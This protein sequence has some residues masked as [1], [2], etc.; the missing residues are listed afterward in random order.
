MEELLIS[1]TANGTR[2]DC[3]A[4]GEWINVNGTWY[5]GGTVEEDNESDNVNRVS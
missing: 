3:E 1:E 5:N 2:L 4:D